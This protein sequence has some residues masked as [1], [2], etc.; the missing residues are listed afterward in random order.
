M[1]AAAQGETSLLEQTA[2]AT[3]SCSGSTA[4]SLPTSG[5]WPRSAMRWSK[6]WRAAEQKKRAKARA[7]ELRPPA[8]SPTALA[9][10]AQD[11]PRRAA[12]RDCAGDCA[13]TTA[14]SRVSAQPRSRRCSRRARARS[15]PDVV[16]VPGRHGD[17][18]R[19]GGDPRGH[20]SSRRSCKRHRRRRDQFA[21]ASEL[22]GA[23]EAALRQRYSVSIN[24]S[25]LAQLME[26]MSQ[27]TGPRVA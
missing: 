18:G 21:C 3:T 17:R 2:T 16:E 26:Q 22:L 25:V 27:V 7:E 23:Y 9:Q 15:R 19:R 8:S 12:G 13:A 10:L 1:F 20:R 4:S 11:N 5:R 24:Q 14:R 6:A